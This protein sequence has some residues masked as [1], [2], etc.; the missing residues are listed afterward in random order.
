MTDIPTRDSRHERLDILAGVWHTD[1]TT[2]AE[3][4]TPG[5]HSTAIDTYRWM[6]GG[7]FL[8]HEVDAYIAG[9]PLQ[10]LE[11]IG[12]DPSGGGYRARSY[13]SRG[14]ITEHSA[15]LDGQTFQMASK[16]DRFEGSFDAEGRK[17]TGRWERMTEGK[18]VPWMDV[19]LTKTGRTN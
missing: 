1:F 3:D 7:F 9:N 8:V 14:A 15:E 10:A 2:L 17:L 5:E 13:D 12:V 18:W 4:G 19:V 6:P 11:I 16:T